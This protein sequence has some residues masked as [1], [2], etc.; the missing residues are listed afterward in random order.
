MGPRSTNQMQGTAILFKAT[1]D[2]EILQEIVDNNSKYIIMDCII[3]DKCYTLANIHLKGE[4]TGGATELLHEFMTKIDTLGNESLIIGGDFNLDLDNPASHFKSVLKTLQKYMEEWLLTDIWHEMHPS[5]VRNTHI[6]KCLASI[7][8]SRFDY[9]LIS[10]NLHNLLVHNS[11]IELSFRSDH[12]PVSLYL[13]L[14]GEHRKGHW[15]FNKALLSDMEYHNKV[16]KIIAQTKL[17]NPDTKA[18]LL[19]DT[20]K[21]NIRG[22]TIAYSTYKN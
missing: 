3:N 5:D 12:A 8:R 22:E 2:Y 4:N 21:C 10:D 7:C 17:D 6:A 18:D 13:N 9:L 19:W 16:H 11:D 20:I 1:L 14:G 15:G